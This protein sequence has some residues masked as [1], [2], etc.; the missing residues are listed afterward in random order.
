MLRIK[1]KFDIFKDEY[2]G[3]YH[4]QAS[5]CIEPR[6]YVSQKE[7]CV[8]FDG[9]DVNDLDVLMKIFPSFKREYFRQVFILNDQLGTIFKSNDKKEIDKFLKNFSRI[10]F[11]DEMDK[12][13]L[14]NIFSEKAESLWKEIEN[15]YRSEDYEDERKKST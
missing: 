6:L 8:L 10:G 5:L 7:Y 2:D 12:Q 9:N 14:R 11:L 15:Y 1:A 3:E 4:L 13:K